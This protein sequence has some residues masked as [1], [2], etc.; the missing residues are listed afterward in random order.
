[1]SRHAFRVSLAFA[2]ALAPAAAFL[3]CSAD[4]TA[5]KARGISSWKSPSLQDRHASTDSGSEKGVAVTRALGRMPLYFIE[6]RGQLDSRVAYYVQGR[7]TT[8]YFTSE[9]MTLVQTDKRHGGNG[10]KGKLER[11]SLSRGISQA[12]DP[13]S[14]WVVKLDFVGANPNPKITAADPTPAVISYFKGPR[15]E[16]K[17]G[18]STYGSIV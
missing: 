5:P 4:R 13:V 10:L 18:L 15:E 12:P 14:R 16:W 6:N 11:V 17:T 9:G 2:A 1:M 3:S 8:L 7:D